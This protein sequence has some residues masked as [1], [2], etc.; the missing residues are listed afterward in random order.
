MSDTSTAAAPVTRAEYEALLARLDRL[1]TKQEAAET[2]I[3][4]VLKSFPAG[5]RPNRPGEHNEYGEWVFE[6]GQYVDGLWEPAA[7]ASVPA[8]AEVAPAVTT[9]AAP[10]ADAAILPGLAHETA[11]QP[12]A[13]VTPPTPDVVSADSLEALIERAVEAR[14]ASLKDTVEGVTSAPVAP[15]APPSGG[16]VPGA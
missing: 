2:G 11:P 7:S 1:Q 9:E 6:V 8:P 15:A 3:V 14:V 4:A 5:E 13:P 10:T 16:S 12:T